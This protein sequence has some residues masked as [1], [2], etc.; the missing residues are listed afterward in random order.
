MRVAR[1]RLRNTLTRVYK[2]VQQ[3]PAFRYLP[4]EG[5]DTDGQYTI[6]LIDADYNGADQ[7]EGVYAFSQV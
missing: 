6:A 4:A 1:L 3:K 5:A 7:S 2:A